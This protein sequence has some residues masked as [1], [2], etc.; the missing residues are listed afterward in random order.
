MGNNGCAW[1][2]VRAAG[3]VAAKRWPWMVMRKPQANGA[4]ALS[5]REEAGDA[6]REAVRG[7]RRRDEGG[8]VTREAA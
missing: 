2:D 3:H 6:R 7:G 1:A 4:A 8:G 5:F